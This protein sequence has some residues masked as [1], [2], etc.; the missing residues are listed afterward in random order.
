VDINSDTI[1]ETRL[2]KFFV[3]LGV[4]LAVKIAIYPQVVPHIVKD[5]LRIESACSYTQSIDHLLTSLCILS[6]GLY[7]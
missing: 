1:H 6:V 4:A 5:E 3:T 2:I 7:S